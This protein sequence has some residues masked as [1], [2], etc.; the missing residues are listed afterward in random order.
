[1]WE[2]ASLEAAEKV[3]NKLYI[4]LIFSASFF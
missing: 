2:S 4:I 1:V 3:S